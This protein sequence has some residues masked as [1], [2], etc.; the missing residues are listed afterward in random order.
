MNKNYRETKKF[1]LWCIYFFDS[2]NKTTHLNATQ[3]AIQAYGYKNDKQYHLA[4][5]TGSKN[6][7]KYEGLGVAITDQHGLSFGELMKIGIEKMKKGTYSDWEKFM[8]KLGYFPEKAPILE[9]NNVFNFLHLKEAITRT[10]EE[11]GLRGEIIDHP[12]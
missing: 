12:L 1:N 10:R 3:S 4:S 8:I 6:M 9:Q 11:R 2:T 5:V 7:R